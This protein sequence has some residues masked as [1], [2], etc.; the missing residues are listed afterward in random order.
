MQRR[1]IPLFLLIWI[2]ILAGCAG[3]GGRGVLFEDD[4]EDSSSGWDVDRYEGLERG[5]QAGVYFIELH[6]P[7]WFTWSTPG[8]R[9]GDVIV[10]A[11]VR[12]ASGAGDGHFG[13]I[14]RHADADNFY[15]FAISPDGYYAILKRTNG[16]FE[17]LTGG[18]MLPT[19][20]VKTGGE[21]NSLMVVC[22]G[23]KL[24]LYVNGERA[25]EVTDGT[26]RKGEF[27]LGAGSGATGSI[28]V[29]FD[30][31]RVTWP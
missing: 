19:Q 2:L 10:E 4:F 16:H 8:R 26:H 28:R 27:G 20:A 24:S 23:E 25:G 11:D 12:L 6:K 18:G 17:V 1:Y 21:I 29:E 31:F 9:A 13:V 30:N 22:R 3:A 14:C 15:Y 5:Y 7:H